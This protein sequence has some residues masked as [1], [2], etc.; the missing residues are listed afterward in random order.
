MDMKELIIILLLTLLSCTSKTQIDGSVYVLQSE[1]VIAPGM[2]VT[3]E[4]ANGQLII[5]AGQNL[6]RSFTWAG[7]TRSVIMV[8]RKERWNG[9]LG[10]YYP[11]DG[12]HWKEHDGITRAVLEEGILHFSSIDSILAYIA[13]YEDKEKITYN[14]N[15]LF[16]AWGKSRGAGGTMNVQLWQFLINGKPPN[17]VPGSHNNKIRIDGKQ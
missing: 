17:G 8:P 9:S 12:S 13:R 1:V 6:Q 14:D 16:I 10:I 11:G 4:N 3:V 5:T 7:D 15:G 2:S